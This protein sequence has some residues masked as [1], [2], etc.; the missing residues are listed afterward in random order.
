V[1]IA[2]DF[3]TDGLF[4]D[5]IRGIPKGATVISKVHLLTAEDID[6]DEVTAWHDDPTL[7]PRTGSLV[8]GVRMVLAADRRYAHNG[9]LYD[10]RVLREFFPAEWAARNPA[11]VALDSQVGAAVCWPT[12]HLR[13]LDSARIA[14]ARAL[15]RLPFPGDCVGRHSLK[16]WGMR[17]G[18]RKAEYDGG[19]A[20]F[21]QAMLG[22]GIQD[23]KTL[24]TL[25]RKLNMK[26]ASG[27][28]TERAWLLEQDF[29]LEIDQMMSNGFAFD[30]KGAEALTARLQIERAELVTRLS[31]AIPPFKN[32]ALTDPDVIKRQA[33]R[34]AM[35]QSRGKPAK[36]EAAL[37]VLEKKKAPKVTLVPFNPGSRHHIARYLQEVHKWSP[38][39][40]DGYTDG[41][42]VKIDETVL[43]S[44]RH[45]PHV[46]DFERYLLLAKRLSQI[47]E[48]RQKNAKPWTE[49][50]K[51]DGRIHGRVDHNGAVSSRVS[52]S[53]PNMSAVPKVGAEF[54]LE[55]RSLFTAGPG[56]VL[57]GGDVKALE[58][59]FLGHYLW[60]VDGGAFAKRVLDGTLYEKVVELLKIPEG[61]LQ[62]DTGK[63]AFL[64]WLYGAG[65]AKMG[66]I[67][68][69]SADQGKAAGAALRR[70]LQVEALQNKLKDIAKRRGTINLPDGRR[71]HVRH[72]HAVLNTLLQGSGAILMKCATVL[73]CRW[74][75]AERLDSKL[76]AFLH[77]ELQFDTAPQDAERVS[78]IITLSIMRAGEEFALRLPFIADVKVGK[79]HAETH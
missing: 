46:P 48:K 18:N 72:E 68:G 53:D 43:E 13:R 67:L 34:V 3:E 47:S 51:A 9:L 12:E 32:V 24:A 1:R 28:L 10:E 76:V 77:D 31:A 78:S 29:K 57:V 54:G 14:K 30:V 52:H 35:W 17:F 4:A 64:A 44:I 7:T 63:R 2:Y 16:A 36:V 27:D 25:V 26:I 19:F 55:C 70:G 79:N 38:D 61:P 40:I 49:C 69:R 21:T 73:A 71:V 42:D 62:R 65:K 20:V 56:R 22:Y 75:R 58:P 6:T 39:P 59:R 41:G 50:V 15:N 66:K 37:A 23:A 11:G 33:E 74:I 5:S 45:L 8:D 60:P